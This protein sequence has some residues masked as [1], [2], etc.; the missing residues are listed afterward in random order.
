LWPSERRELGERAK[1]QLDSLRLDAGQAAA[2]EDREHQCSQVIEEMFVARD[3]NAVS[4][5][6]AFEYAANLQ[7][8]LP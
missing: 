5:C 3:G 8:C 6:E 2:I 1:P 4:G 7:S